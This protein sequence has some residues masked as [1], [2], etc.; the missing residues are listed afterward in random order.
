MPGTDVNIAA[1]ERVFNFPFNV[2]HIVPRTRGDNTLD[3]LAL[4]CESCNLFKS[5]VTVSQD[6]EDGQ[7]VDL[8]HPRRD[9][10][11]DHF[12]FDEGTGEINGITPTGRATVVR[13]QINSAFQLRA[14]R[15]LGAS[16][17]VSLMRRIETGL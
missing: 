10:W 5:D 3:N 17:S 4:A 7:L 6:T 11:T 2:D 13:L 1:P 15:T 9:R 12:R 16:R 8:F 14:P